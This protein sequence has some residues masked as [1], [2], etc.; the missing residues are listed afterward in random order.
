M[1]NLS[2]GQT[3][4][5][6]IIGIG[7]IFTIMAWTGKIAGINW[8]NTYVGNYIIML[9]G[10]FLLI[11]LLSTILDLIQGNTPPGIKGFLK[12]FIQNTVSI[13]IEL[14]TLMILSP[15]I[16]IIM[17]TFPL[18]VIVALASFVGL[19]LYFIEDILNYNIIGYGSFDNGTQALI[20]IAALAFSIFVLSKSKKINKTINSVVEKV[21]SFSHSIEEKLT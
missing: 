9:V 21:I 8:T 1:K 18:M 14:T 11:Q 5:S 16:I 3:I 20:A 15:T 19:V 10:F 13:T 4:A 12:K 2:I 6:I 7:G 17:L